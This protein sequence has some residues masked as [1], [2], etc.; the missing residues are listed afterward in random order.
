LAV[1][2]PACAGETMSARHLSPTTGV[3]PR[4]RGGDGGRSAARAAGLGP[5]PRARGRR[6]V[7]RQGMRR[8]RSIPACAGETPSSSTHGGSSG[9]H[10]RVRGGDRNCYA[11]RIAARGPSPRA[12]GR[13][14]SFTKPNFLKGSIPACAGETPCMLSPNSSTRVHP[15]V[16]GGDAVVG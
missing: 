7:R 1:W 4:V 9:V 10:P 11:A 2:I 3:H 8:G 12:R 16:R 13:Q 6:W 14:Y 15:R 5:S